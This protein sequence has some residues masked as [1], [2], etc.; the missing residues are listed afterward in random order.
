M[1]E[2]LYYSRNAPT[3]GN[4]GSDL[5]K[6]GRMDIAIHIVINS[7]FMSH[8]IRRETKL[9]LLFAGQPD[10]VKH[11]EIQAAEPKEHNQDER[12]DIS[13][14]DISGLIKRALYKYKKGQKVETMPGVTVEKKGFMELVEEL[15]ESGREIYILDKDGEDIRT[16]K[17]GTH[18][19]FVL[20]DQDGIPVKELRRLKK[21]FTPVSI[22]KT[23]YFASQ[24]VSIVNNELDRREESAE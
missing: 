15:Q 17:L 13:K 7:L 4:F 3:T 20:G 22:G 2:F 14:K 6:A 21:G 10:P 12:S 11:I 1:R 8:A 9:H 24:T 18:P 19:V 5:M 23:T 16:V